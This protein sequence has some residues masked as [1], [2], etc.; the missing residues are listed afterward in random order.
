MPSKYF[1]FTHSAVKFFITNLA[2][3]EKVVLVGFPAMCHDGR[4]KRC[5]LVT[6]TKESC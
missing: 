6:E 3:S 4:I 5:V 1:L 2:S